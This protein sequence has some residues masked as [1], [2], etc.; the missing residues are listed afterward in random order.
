MKTR[1]IQQRL[2]A[3]LVMCTV[4]GWL[5]ADDQVLWRTWGVRDTVSRK[6]YT[7]RLSV[8]PNG[9]AYSRHGAVRFM[10]VFDGY[11]TSRPHPGATTQTPAL[12]ADVHSHL[13]LPGLQ[14]RGWCRKATC[15][16]SGTGSG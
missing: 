9:E 8:T 5:R 10:S 6:S 16:S 15:A 1:K 14:I 11:G 2:V 13:H 12:L 4:A 7:Y 3:V